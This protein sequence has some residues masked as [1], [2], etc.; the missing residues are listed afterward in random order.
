MQL[1]L[2]RL[3]A[4]LSSFKAENLQVDPKKLTYAL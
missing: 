1:I 3:D 4:K 2:S